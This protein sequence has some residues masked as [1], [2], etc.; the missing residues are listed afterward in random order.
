MRLVQ[1]YLL[2]MPVMIYV[3][4]IIL[5]PLLFDISLDELPTEDDPD[6]EFPPGFEN[7]ILFNGILA[8]V[9]MMFFLPSN[10]SSDRI[11]L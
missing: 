5:G 2:F 3:A 4:L 9:P 10:V 8:L 11:D 6:A 1:A 7:Y